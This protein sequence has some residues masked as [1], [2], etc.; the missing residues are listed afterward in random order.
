MKVATCQKNFEIASQDFVLAES[1]LVTHP[2]TTE[3]IR[4][5]LIYSFQASF[6]NN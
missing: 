3:Y 5:I 2:R 6:S 4:A 1:Y